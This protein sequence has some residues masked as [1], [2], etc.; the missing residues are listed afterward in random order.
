MSRFGDT[1]ANTGMMTLM[2]SM[3]ATKDLNVGVKTATASAAA[4]LFRIFL[5]PVVSYVF[6]Y[7]SIEV[8]LFFLFMRCLISYSCLIIWLMKQTNIVGYCQDYNASHW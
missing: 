7:Q 6:V 4:A 1:A 3:D 5:M 2:D 8:M